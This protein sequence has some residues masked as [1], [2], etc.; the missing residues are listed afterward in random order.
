MNRFSA[1]ASEIFS[2]AIQDYNRGIIIGEQTF[3]KGTV[4][5]LLDLERFLPGK[6][7]KPGQVKLTLAKFYRVTGSSTQHRGVTPDIE[8]P[9]PYSAEEFGESSEPSALPWDQIS[10]TDFS[11]FDNVDEDVLSQLKDSNKNR[12]NN[13]AYLIELQ[14]DVENRKKS[15]RSDSVSLNL[16]ARMKEIENNEKLS[17]EEIGKHTTEQA[18]TWPN[19]W[20]KLYNKM[21]PVITKEAETVPLV[22]SELWAKAY[23]E[24]WEGIK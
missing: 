16:E 13:S 24:I 3:G 18:K 19:D 12:L 15:L 4:Q 17:A 1:S 7:E 21:V 8:L 23:L 14:I 11:T 10:A 2:G 5:N 6:N 9:T 20:K 22:T